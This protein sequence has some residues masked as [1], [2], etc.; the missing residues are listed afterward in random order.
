MRPYLQSIYSGIGMMLRNPGM[1]E[2]YRLSPEVVLDLRACLDLLVDGRMITHVHIQHPDT[3]PTLDVF[4][5]ST[6]E[7]SVSTNIPNAKISQTRTIKVMACICEPHWVRVTTDRIHMLKDVS[8]GA[9]PSRVIS[10]TQADFACP[11]DVR[12]GQV[13]LN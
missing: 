9:C 8:E 3:L 11:R 6:T 7:P 10:E 4:I 2:T 1:H 5:G 13:Y 12:R